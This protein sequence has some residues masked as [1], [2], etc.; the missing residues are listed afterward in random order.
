MPERTVDIGILAT[1][2]RRRPPEP[3]RKEEGAV[4]DAD[5][6][7]GASREHRLER[8]NMPIY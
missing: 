4:A 5:E 2:E 1:S 3:T 8:L 6:T 7:I